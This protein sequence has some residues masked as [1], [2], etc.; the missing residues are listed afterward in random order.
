[1][2]V[3]SIAGGNAVIQ[4]RYIAERLTE[5]LGKQFVFDNRG[6]ASGIGRKVVKAAGIRVDQ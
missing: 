2:I 4:A 1:M 6:G 3:P 5:A